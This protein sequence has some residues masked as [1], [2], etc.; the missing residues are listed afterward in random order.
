MKLIV[1]ND[2]EA[3]SRRA[4][5]LVIEYILQ[6]P[7]SVLVLATGNSPLGMFA[8]LV[9]AYQCGEVSFKQCSL[10]E[11]D[12]YFNISQDDHRNLYNWLAAEFIS[13]V[14]I[15]AKNI[16][17]FNTASANPHAGDHIVGSINQK[18]CNTKICYKK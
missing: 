6:N 9:S 11:L 15:L 10:I 1:T 12:D 8:K 16:V 2:Y 4:A 14:D 3:L 13:Q 18:L 5:G 7:A 17:R